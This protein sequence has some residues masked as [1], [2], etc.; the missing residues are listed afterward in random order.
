[1]HCITE[2]AAG[3][4]LVGQGWGEPQHVLKPPA[5]PSP[6]YYLSLHL[7]QDRAL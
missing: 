6:H 4:M 5:E 3:P 1:M 2:V 7:L